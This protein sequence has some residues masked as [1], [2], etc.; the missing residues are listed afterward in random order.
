MK[1][2]FLFICGRNQWCGPTAEY[3]YRNDDRIEGR[4]AGMSASSKHILSAD[5]VAWADLVLVMENRYKT[6]IVDTFR[7]L[8]LPE[9]ANL[10]IPDDYQYMDAELA[11]IIQKGVEFYIKQVE[12]RARLP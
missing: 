5:D 9:I 7:G 11:N 3:I 12:H 4:S 10:D 8:P 1:T 6:R 2:H